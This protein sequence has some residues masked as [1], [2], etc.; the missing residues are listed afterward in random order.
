MAKAALR[1][2]LAAAKHPQ[3]SLA[4]K[5]TPAIEAARAANRARGDRGAVAL[6]QVWR[7]QHQPC[8]PVV[9]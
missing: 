6:G 7:A 9:A 2:H 3:D 5:V 8:I 1:A 4:D